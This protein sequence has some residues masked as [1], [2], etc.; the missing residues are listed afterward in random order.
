MKW[1]ITTPEE[2]TDVDQIKRAVPAFEEMVHGLGHD[3]FKRVD[4]DAVKLYNWIKEHETDPNTFTRLVIDQENTVVGGITGTLDT[5]VYS[6]A[7]HA[8]ERMF[9]L[10]P[11]VKD[12]TLVIPLLDAFVRWAIEAGAVDVIIGNSTGINLVGFDKLA[13]HL[14]FEPATLGYIRRTQ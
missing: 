4:I 7:V 12:R 9:Y 13:K 2:L 1:R 10:D 3:L 11:T 6:S 14:G 5:Y 8:F